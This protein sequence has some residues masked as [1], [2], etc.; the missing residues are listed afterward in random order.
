MCLSTGEI[1]GIGG[2]LLL[3]TATAT[4]RTVRIL[5]NQFPEIESW[6][7]ILNLPYRR[8]VTILVPPMEDI[9]SRFEITLEPFVDRMKSKNETYLILVRGKYMI[10][11]FINVLRSNQQTKTH[12]SKNQC[13][14]ILFWSAVSVSSINGV[15][16]CSHVH[17][18][19]MIGVYAISTDLQKTD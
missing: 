16:Q 13:K 7:T 10:P 9:S 4:T 2:K 1:S 11:Y 15:V 6:K 19:T 8:N 5:K 3:M 17:N 14:V 18:H 12:T